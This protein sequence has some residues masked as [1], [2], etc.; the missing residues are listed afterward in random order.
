MDL[1]HHRKHKTLIMYS[2]VSYYDL[3]LQIDS[4]HNLLTCLSVDL[5]RKESAL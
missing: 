4:Y 1:E 5:P 3:A 2:R